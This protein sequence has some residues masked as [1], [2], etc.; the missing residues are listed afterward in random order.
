MAASAW[1][2][3]HCETRLFSVHLL[4]RMYFWR[5]WIK[6]INI[7][8]MFL[9][10]INWKCVRV[11]CST[12]SFRAFNGQLK[13]WHCENL[14]KLLWW[15]IRSSHSDMI[16]KITVRWSSLSSKDKIKYDL[17]GMYFQGLVFFR[18]SHRRCFIE[19]VVKNFSKFTGKDLYQSLFF[20]KVAGL[21]P[22]TL[23]KKRL[24]QRCF[25]VNFEKFLRAPF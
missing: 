3:L 15:Q 16:C 10:L 4:F 8:S 22:G 6:W 2:N 12:F 20:N 9:D 13:R 14:I 19:K 7:E 21:R 24:W 11:I 5:I 23:L 18:S 25:P 17:I 1:W